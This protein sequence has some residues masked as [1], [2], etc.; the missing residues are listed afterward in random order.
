MLSKW[1]SQQN[2]K[3]YMI[4]TNVIGYSRLNTWSLDCVSCMM[5]CIDQCNEN[6]T[7]LTGWLYQE[8]SLGS[9]S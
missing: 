7:I 4:V 1:A 5:K 8:Q 9:N 2:N 3:D 6:M